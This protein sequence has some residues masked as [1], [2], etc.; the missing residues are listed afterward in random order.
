MFGLM[1]KRET[2]TLV[3]ATGALLLGLAGLGGVSRAE[4]VES[5]TTV[6]SLDALPPVV[7]I[8]PLGTGIYFHGGD[9]VSFEWTTSDAHPGTQ[10]S[11]FMAYVMVDA[12]PYDQIS[13]YPHIDEYIWE[14]P[15]PELLSPEVFLQLKVR[16]AFGNVTV[17]LGDEFTI[18]PASVAVDVVP[19]VPVLAPPYPNPFNPVTNLRFSLPV[20]GRVEIS[21]YDVR[22]RQV[23]RLAGGQRDAGW[24]D[25]VWDGLSDSGQPCAGGV[26][27][28]V[29]R[30]ESPT[31][32]YDLLQKV[33][34][35][36]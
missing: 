24:H 35:V 29:M 19:G 12:A 17:A 6:G 21:V 27:A 36:P 25:L 2:T 32:R 3:L 9:E 20:A 14:W 18:L 4:V 7:A 26:Y 33:V 28:V 23:R 11:D 31:G 10:A 22:G 8:T 5:V 30:A 34:L 1:I 16:D 13:F 15:V